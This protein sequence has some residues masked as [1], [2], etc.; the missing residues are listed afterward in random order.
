VVFEER[1]FLE[2][3]AVHG[4]RQPLRRLRI[5]LLRGLDALHIA[6]DEFQF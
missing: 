4:L 1:F 3:A 5:N 2:A 6:G